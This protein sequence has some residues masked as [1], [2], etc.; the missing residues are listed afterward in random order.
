MKKAI[1][2]NI[3]QEKDLSL[4]LKQIDMEKILALGRLS[5]KQDAVKKQILKRQETLS[6][7][8]KVQLFEQEAANAE[9]TDGPRPDERVQKRPV[10]R[11]WFYDETRHTSMV[12]LPALR[13]KRR[14]LSVS[15]FWRTDDDS[16]RYASRQE[17]QQ[18]PLN[19]WKTGPLVTRIITS[20]QMKN[21]NPGER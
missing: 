11:S 9:A 16:M 14:S 4:I 3:K 1:E 19:A 5:R 15:A 20:S 2:R 21:F 17:A 13:N 12:Y 10:R 7:Q 8:I 6:K 18:H